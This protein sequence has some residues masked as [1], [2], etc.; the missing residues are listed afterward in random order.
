MVNDICSAIQRYLIHVLARPFPLSFHC[1]CTCLIKGT[2][3][4]HIATAVAHRY[5]RFE[6][7]SHVAAVHRA[8]PG[9]CPPPR[10]LPSA[11]AYT[12]SRI[13][14]HGINSTK[15]VPSGFEYELVD[16]LATAV[17]AAE[18]DGTRERGRKFRG[19]LFATER[20]DRIAAV[21]SENKK[22]WKEAPE[23]VCW[24]PRDSPRLPR[25]VRMGLNEV[26]R[27]RLFATK[28]PSRLPR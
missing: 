27:G 4:S 22:G 12:A 10:G 18:T 17:P 14:G 2:P 3:R 25:C 1:I 19:D 13:K 16:E 6:P 9:S 20:Q 21:H 15:R 23:A 24:I 11:T 7:L 26:S 28:R 8:F 5:F